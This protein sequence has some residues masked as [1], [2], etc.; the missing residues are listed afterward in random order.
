[1]LWGLCEGLSGV[2]GLDI[3]TRRQHSI[4]NT[5]DSADVKI[6]QIARQEFLATVAHYGQVRQTG[7]RI[8]HRGSE[9]S[10]PAESGC[11]C[12]STTPGLHTLLDDQNRTLVS[13]K[14]KGMIE[15]WWCGLVVP[16]GRD[17]C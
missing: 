6:K 8:S 16:L 3:S 2:I 5:F 12:C 1:M 13:E 11:H 14:N 7:S 4:V 10:I 17:K 15:M 9:L